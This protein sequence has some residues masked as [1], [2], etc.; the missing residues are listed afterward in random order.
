MESLS[1]D[2]SQS[3]EDDVIPIEVDRERVL[4]CSFEALRDVS[5]R[6][7]LMGEYESYF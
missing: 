1:D 2:S 4:Q 5:S 6:Q 7:L 3:V